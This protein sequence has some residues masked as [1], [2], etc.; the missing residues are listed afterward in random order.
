[1]LLGAT[2]VGEPILSRF[3]RAGFAAEPFKFTAASKGALIDNLV[4]AA[5]SAAERLSSMSA[6]VALMNTN[7]VSPLPTGK[8]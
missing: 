1:M 5:V 2:E 8:W 4:L 3:K 7:G 6:L